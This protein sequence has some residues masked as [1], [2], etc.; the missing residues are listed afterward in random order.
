[1]GGLATSL[2]L[3]AIL[4]KGDSAQTLG[5][6]ASITFKQNLFLSVIIPDAALCFTGNSSQSTAVPV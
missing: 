4:H 1:M 5:H 3:T 6:T 2:L